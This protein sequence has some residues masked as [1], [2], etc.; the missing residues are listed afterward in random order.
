[1]SQSVRLPRELQSEIHCPQKY[2]RSARLS[3][4][5]LFH[6]H[7]L[8]PFR[9]MAYYKAL[10]VQSASQILPA[11]PSEIH[12]GKPGTVL[13]RSHLPSPSDRWLYP[14]PGNSHTVFHNS[15]PLPDPDFHIPYHQYGKCQ[16][17]PYSEC[18]IFL[19]HN[20][21]SRYYFLHLQTAP[22][23]VLFRFLRCPVRSKMLSSRS[24]LSS[25]Y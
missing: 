17:F 10:S 22:H 12:P 6:S 14:S 9:N 19:N 18:S 4:C 20:R 23:P 1:M 25:Y 16:V 15:L 13:V 3:P 5:A 8:H 11:P 7:G 24:L 21:F 2:T